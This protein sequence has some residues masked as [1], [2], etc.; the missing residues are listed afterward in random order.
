MADTS[1]NIAARPPRIDAGYDTPTAQPNRFFDTTVAMAR[2]G[3]DAALA[4][5]EASRQGVGAYLANMPMALLNLGQAGVGGFAGLIAD[6][7]PGLDAATERDLAREIL[8]LPE[9]FMGVSPGRVSNVLDDALESGAEAARFAGARLNQPGPMPETLFSGFGPTG[10]P[11]RRSPAQEARVEGTGLTSPAFRRALEI[12][13]PTAPASQ[14]LRTLIG[15]N[16]RVEQELRWS[17][18]YQELEALGDKVIPLGDLQS[19]VGDRA[20]LF[21][22]ETLRGRGTTGAS[23]R[24]PLLALIAEDR[25]I[26]ELEDRIQTEVSAR[27]FPL[28]RILNVSPEA[29]ERRIQSLRSGGVYFSEDAERSPQDYVFDR[30]QNMIVPSN[31]E[32]LRDLVLSSEMGE[33]APRTFDSLIMSYA[34]QDLRNLSPEE[35]QALTE[36]ARRRVAAE[37]LRFYGAP[38][39]TSYSGYVLPGARDYRENIVRIGPQVAAVRGSQNSIVDYYARTHYDRNVDPAKL[40]SGEVPVYHTRT[41]TLPFRNNRPGREDMSPDGNAHF[42][43][44]AQSDAQQRIRTEAPSINLGVYDVTGSPEVLRNRYN[45]LA[46]EGRDILADVE[47]LAMQWHQLGREAFDLRRTTIGLEEVPPDVQRRLDEIGEERLQLYTQAERDAM[48]A[49]GQGSPLRDILARTL[50]GSFNERIVR[51]PDQPTQYFVPNYAI[52][53]GRYDDFISEL[54]PTTAEMGLPLSNTSSEWLDHAL[55]RE[56][57]V[58][59]DEGRDALILTPGVLPQRYSKGTPGVAA[60]Y[61]DIGPK[62]MQNLLRQL[63][64]KKDA[65]ELERVWVQTQEDGWLEAPVIRIND[66]LI[67]RVEEVGLRNFRD[68]GEVR[69]GIGGLNEVARGMFR[70]PRAEGF[71]QG[72]EVMMRSNMPEQL[73]QGI[74]SLNEV[75]RGMYRGGAVQGFQMGGAVG[76]HPLDQYGQYLA[77]TYAQPIQQSASDAVN[78][79]VESVRQKEQSYFGGGMGGGLMGSPMQGGLMGSS[80]NAGSTLAVGGLSPPMGQVGALSGNPMQAAMQSGTFDAQVAAAQK[81]EQRAKPSYLIGQ[82]VDRSGHE[83]TGGGYGVLQN[84]FA[85]QQLGGMQMGAL[86]AQQPLVTSGLNPADPYDGMRG[87][88]VLQP[89]TFTAAPSG[90][91]PFGNILGNRARLGIV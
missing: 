30:T 27:F 42:I 84:P 8:A 56:L 61:D 16:P 55:R 19:Y 85:A 22:V 10:G 66:A 89:G 69:R 1:T 75:A 6:V 78:Q 43:A 57:R 73:H 72:G 50:R 53:E 59:I 88:G 83:I 46:E 31:P 15:N 40:A 13:Q 2:P 60:F 80:A 87:F 41:V 32:Y 62:R 76:G 25:V 33:G 52:D 44:E 74:G 54:Y 64:G 81:I 17:G 36:E 4:N 77:Q 51:P 3:L 28:D 91:S 90:P 37:D 11:P 39:D 34:E 71:A 68:G 67:D 45:A 48:S 58:A 35:Y 14:Y 70:G 5:L 38:G 12:T 18:A 63:F 21:S 29:R 65:P 24:D 49:A 86:S 26:P 23:T 82:E 20:D 79:F 47:P 9:A 7:V